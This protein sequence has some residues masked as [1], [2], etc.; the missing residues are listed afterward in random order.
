MFVG[1]HA[2]YYSNVKTVRR[3][4]DCIVMW[5]MC[6]C[7][8]MPSAGRIFAVVV[9]VFL[10]LPNLYH[11]KLKTGIIGKSKKFR[12]WFRCASKQIHKMHFSQWKHKWSYISGQRNENETTKKRELLEMN[13]LRVNVLQYTWW[14]EMPPKMDFCSFDFSHEKKR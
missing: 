10:I 12:F 9:Y 2:F 8:E 6:V 7:C 3:I 13:D 5:R 14:V 4:V 1:I 11:K